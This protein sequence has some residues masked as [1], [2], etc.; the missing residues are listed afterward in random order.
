[1]IHSVEQVLKLALLT[2]SGFA[3][4][5]VIGL[6]VYGGEVFNPNSVGF[7]FVSYGLSGSFIFAVAHVRGVGDT[8]TAAL[9]VSVVQFILASVWITMLNAGIWTFGLNLPIILVA[10]LFERKLAPWRHFKFVVVALLYGAMFVL[11]TLVVALLTGTELLPP[12][13]FQKNFLDGLLIGLG[14]GL[15]LEGGEAFLHSLNHRSTAQKHA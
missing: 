11:L 6:L 3:A 13:L 4:S 9:A 2:L 8:I 10:F 12:T 5:V 14:V 1:M 7:S 15:G